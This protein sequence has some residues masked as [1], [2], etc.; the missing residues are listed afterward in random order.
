VAACAFGFR[1]DSSET[2][3]W[4]YRLPQVGTFASWLRSTAEDAGG[5][6]L[7]TE[8]SMGRRQAGRKK[9]ALAYKR[10]NRPEK[11]AVGTQM[12]PLDYFRS[13]NWHLWTT[14]VTG[15]QTPGL[16]LQIRRFAVRSDPI[17]L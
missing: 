4:P 11:S 14:F 13:R 6:A 8:L 7:A 17:N 3:A 15:G 2:S 16:A 1:V 5:Y 10:G 9:L 12:E